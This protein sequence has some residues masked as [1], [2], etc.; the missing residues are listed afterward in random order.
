MLG[1]AKPG[2]L[3]K[4][5]GESSSLCGAQS[6]P[7]KGSGPKA[8]SANACKDGRVPRALS[9]P[10]RHLLP[11]SGQRRSCQDGPDIPQIFR[12]S[13]S[14]PISCQEGLDGFA[15][16]PEAGCGRKESET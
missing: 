15:L 9:C 12:D 16:F 8:P 2:L 10:P 6:I 5:P 1:G 7:A 3:A 11:P 4:V 14:L 13:P